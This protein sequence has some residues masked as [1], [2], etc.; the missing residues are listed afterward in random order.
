MVFFHSVCCY[1]VISS[2]ASVC[3]QPSISWQRPEVRNI[4]GRKIE[5][6]KVLD[7]NFTFALKTGQRLPFLT[8]M[9]EHTSAPTLG[10]G[11]RVWKPRCLE[12][13]TIF[14]NLH[15]IQSR[16]STSGQDPLCKTYTQTSPT[17][18]VVRAQQH[19]AA[20]DLA[21]FLCSQKCHSS[22]ASQGRL[23]GPCHCSN[24]GF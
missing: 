7:I 5:I 2:L 4:C 13:Q 11:S 10:P 24:K 20:G 1:L 15:S 21:E 19:R 18:Q 3:W 16:D 17:R 12:I 6:G 23:W 14:N 8:L 22:Q 9:P